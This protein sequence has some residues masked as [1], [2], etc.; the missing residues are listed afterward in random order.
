MGD[1]LGVAFGLRAESKT[2]SSKHSLPASGLRPP[3][4]SVDANPV[5][6]EPA[7]EDSGH[8]TGVR[9]SPNLNLNRLEERSAEEGP[10]RRLT[11]GVSWPSLGRNAFPYQS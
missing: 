2:R 9:P 3:V 1:G 8:A 7:S 11:D 4:A 5:N 10:G 6:R